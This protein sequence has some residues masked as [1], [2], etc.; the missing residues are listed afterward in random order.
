ME[1]KV[2]AEMHQH[3]NTEFNQQTYPIGY[4]Y[5]C[6]SNYNRL[7]FENL[8]L[9]SVYNQS[10]VGGKSL[11]KAISEKKWASYIFKQ[12]MHVPANLDDQLAL[13]ENCL[14]YSNG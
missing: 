1:G 11:V 4:D 2:I 7:N 5:H 12:T 8:G 13:M 3:K 6:E 9:S 14:I 10:S